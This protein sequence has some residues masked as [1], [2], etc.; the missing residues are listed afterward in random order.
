MKCI[1]SLHDKE[2]RVAHV[3]AVYMCT[4]HFL[5]IYYFVMPWSEV[6]YHTALQCVCV[7]ACSACTVWSRQQAKEGR[8]MHAKS[9]GKNQT[10]SLSLKVHLII[11]P[12]RRSAA[13]PACTVPWP[14]PCS[15]S[16]YIGVLSRTEAAN[17]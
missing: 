9:E 14:A 4:R 1:H 17:S 11:F 5:Y 6:A 12:D 3:T 10:S 13:D 8:D 2:R 16:T 15:A 7:H